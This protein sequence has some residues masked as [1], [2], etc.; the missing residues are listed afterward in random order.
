MEA[1]LEKIRV[2]DQVTWRRWLHQHA[3]LSFEEFETTAYIENLLRDV[4]NLTIERPAP[5]GLVATLHGA[6]PGK[7][8]ALR[9][10]IDALPM[11][12]LADVP[13]KSINPG[14]MHSCGHDVHAAI[15]LG[16]V[17]ALADMRDAIHG[18]VKFIFQ[19]AEEMPPGGAIALVEAGV[20]DDVDQMA[21][22]S[23]L[24]TGFFDTARCR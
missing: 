13:Y 4:P 12:E 10:D 2:A 23:R 8:I 19:A 9:A 1:L 17:F 21:L 22:L 24:W 14:V 6:H 11:D 16:A 15:L 3:E 20:L 5:T 18:D 7:T